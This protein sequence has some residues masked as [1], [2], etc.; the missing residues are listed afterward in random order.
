MNAGLIPLP[1]VRASADQDQQHERALVVAFLEELLKACPWLPAIEVENEP[2]ARFDVDDYINLATVVGQEVKRVN[3]STK[4]IVAAETH[5]FSSGKAHDYWP[6]VKKALDPA[7]YDAVAVHPYR[8][9]KPWSFSAFG[10]REKEWDAIKEAVGEKEIWIT[11]TGWKANEDQHI[12]V[13]NDLDYWR[14]LGAKSV[15]I[16]AFVGHGN[17]FGLYEDTAP[18]T[19][20]PAAVQLAHYFEE[21]PI[22]TA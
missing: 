8:N 12:N 16:Y 10:S 15:C 2:S 21:K 14:S 13:V 3:P 17:D 9:P 5:D 20:R 6:K 18:W 11:E 22:E 4:V 1:I 19:P 7:L